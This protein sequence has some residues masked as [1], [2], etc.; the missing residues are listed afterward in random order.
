MLLV[1]GWPLGRAHRL[2]VLQT[3][4]TYFQALD[5]RTAMSCGGVVV[6]DGVEWW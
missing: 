1:K 4:H 5:K 2:V 6:T 3:W